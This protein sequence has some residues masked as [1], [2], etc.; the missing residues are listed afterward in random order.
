[1]KSYLVTISRG[2]SYTPIIESVIADSELQA[3]NHVVLKHKPQNISFAVATESEKASCT[4]NNDFDLKLK[5]GMYTTEKSP[6]Y[7]SESNI[8]SCEL[9]GQTYTFDIG[10]IMSDMLRGSPAQ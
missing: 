4:E 3:I 2:A 1:M 9:G 7:K 8:F 6:N 5:D 10:S